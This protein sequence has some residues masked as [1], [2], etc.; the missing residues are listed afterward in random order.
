MVGRIMATQRWPC[1]NPQNV[2]IYYLDG[3][4]DIADE[5]VFLD[6]LGGPDL[7]TWALQR[8][9]SFPA[10]VREMKLKKKKER[11]KAWEEQALLLALKTE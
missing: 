7:I 4:I 1:P 11:F 10:E 2:W 9:E 5:E 3:K 8:V 6:Y